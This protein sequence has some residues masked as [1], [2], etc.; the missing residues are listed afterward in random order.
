MEGKN[1]KKHKFPPTKRM[2]QISR[3]RNAFIRDTFYKYAH[4]ICRLMKERNLSF[5]IIGHNKGQKKGSHMGH[6][7]NQH[8]ASIPF[9]RFH[10]IIKTVASQYG[11]SVILQEESYTS[12]ACFIAGDALPVYGKEKSSSFSGKRIHRGL[13]RDYNDIVLNA[14][15]NASANIGRKYNPDIFKGI[16]DFSYLYGIPKVLKHP[17]II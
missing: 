10:Q 14:D 4:K 11:I 9:T 7:N 8:F 6:E 5:L 13:Y 16:A 12:K 1:P 15:V 2:Q 3:K 17:D